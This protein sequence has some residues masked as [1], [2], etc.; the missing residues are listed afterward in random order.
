MK[1]KWHINLIKTIGRTG[2]V[3]LLAFAVF[4]AN[5]SETKTT[6]GTTPG[7]HINVSNVEVP[8]TTKALDD[9]TIQ[10]ISSVSSDG[11]ITFSENTLQL[12]L[13]AKNDIIAVGI[14]TA[15]PNGLLRK[16]TDKQITG[17]NVVVTTAEATMV[18][19]FRSVSL[20]MRQT[21]Q[22]DATAPVTALAQGVTY[23]N[24]VIDK[25][26]G[27]VQNTPP[28]DGT[29]IVGPMASIGV[30][31]NNVKLYSDSSGNSVT[32]NGGVKLGISF[33]FDLD[34]GY[35]WYG[36]PYLES[37][38]FT[39][40]ATDDAAISVTV[41]G[42]YSIDKKML[43]TAIPQTPIAFS[44]GP[45][46]VVIIP[47][48]NIYLGV[49]GRIST[50]MYSEVSQH[51]VFQAGFAYSVDGGWV[52]VNPP[53]SE[54]HKFIPPSKNGTVYAKAYAGP[55]LALLFYGVL[56]PYA[57][58]Y[59][60]VK[61]DADITQ[62]PWWKLH[63]GLTANLGIKMDIFILKWT[64][65]WKIL[66]ETWL[67]AEAGDGGSDSG[68]AAYIPPP[69]PP[70][71]LTATSSACK[72][73]LNWDPAP[74]ADYYNVYRDGVL[75]NSSFGTF[76]L[77]SYTDTPPG[78][79]LYSYYVKAGGENGL[80][81]ASAPVSIVNSCIPNS[82]VNLNGISGYN[83]V[84]LQW[85][86]FLNDGLPAPYQVTQYN[87][88]RT[89]AC[90][91][92]ACPGQIFIGSVGPTP[93]NVKAFTDVDATLVS[94]NWY[95]YLV[96]AVNSKG[97]G[98]QSKGILIQVKPGLVPTI[99]AVKNTVNVKSAD[100]S[101]VQVPGAISYTIYKQVLSGV[102][103]WI[104]VPLITIP[105]PQTT[106]SDTS[107]LFRNSYTYY[108]TATD[109]TGSS[110]ASNSVSVYIDALY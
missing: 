104:W 62:T 48:V 4:T 56:G 21:L 25:N 67:I 5:C 90:L 42:G 95:N 68:S 2:L 81:A 92:I 82:P 96:T 45:I 110:A 98:S 94:G 93:S 30:D 33:D 46:P 60:Y 78:T 24:L 74:R 66:D 52:P 108:V 11:T 54:T 101:W 97:E 91:F 65:N 18:D 79:V 72:I 44:I 106:Y 49:D 32:V 86:D 100:L 61:L 35:K 19:A 14:T 23:R 99:L 40:T 55:E 29:N 57:D 17:T 9:V 89:V 75:I 85:E 13:L 84:N 103:I 28:A 12:M 71:N 76:S 83:K 69:N 102:G 77:P 16:V 50:E 8:A 31:F 37:L 39:T 38:R 15:T 22:P 51:S 88:Y 58:A 53:I 3:P 10:K 27:P 6:N 26:A 34:I 73:N 109:L 64:H 20:S 63:G 80:G 1:L 43:I 7:D 87:V 41:K 105:D 70:T 36:I 107:V 59:A 47:T